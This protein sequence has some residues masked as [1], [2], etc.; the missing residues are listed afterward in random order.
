MR[1]GKRSKDEARNAG[2]SFT[3][4]EVL[5]LEDKKYSLKCSVASTCE[6]VDFVLHSVEASG[7]FVTDHWV[8]PS[9]T[10]CGA[11]RIHIWGELQQGTA[12]IIVQSHGNRKPG[13]FK[14]ESS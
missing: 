7:L 8:T 1:L 13:S 9:C 14:T 10:K 11:K 3:V 12:P 5:H 6:D 2:S 4:V